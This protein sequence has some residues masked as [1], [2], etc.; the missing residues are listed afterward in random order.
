MS[1]KS[2]RDFARKARKLA[3][4]SAYDFARNFEKAIESLADEID[5]IRSGEDPDSVRP[6]KTRE[7][8]KW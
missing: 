5:A 6:A 4:S 1:T 3:P 8:I 7:R 2:A